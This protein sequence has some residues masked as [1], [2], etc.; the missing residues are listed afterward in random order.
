MTDSTNEA[1]VTAWEV[2][3][4]IDYNKLVKQFGVDVIDDKLK[5]RF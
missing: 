5:E 2:R 1:I 3:G 4:K